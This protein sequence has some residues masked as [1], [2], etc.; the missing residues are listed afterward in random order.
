[1]PLVASVAQDVS[2]PVIA[3]LLLAARCRLA[4][5]ELAHPSTG[6]ILDATGASRSRAFELKKRL[7]ELLGGLARPSGRPPLPEPEPPPLELVFEVRDY[8]FDHPGCVTVSEV[9]REYSVEFRQFV[10]ELAER[11]PELTRDVIANAVGVP[12]GTLKDWLASPVEDPESAVQPKTTPDDSDV[13]S[14]RGLHIETVLS[15]W[16]CWRG[17]FVAFCNHLQQHCGVPFGRTLIARVLE[18]H[19]VRL[20][21]KRSGRSPDELALRGAFETFFPHAQWVGDGTMIPVEVDGELSV[22]NAE[23]HVD[24][25]S[26][27]F[28]GVHVS[29]VEDSGAVIAAFRDAIASTGRQPLALLLDNKPSN[30]TDD[31]HQ[32]VDPTMVIRATAYRPQNKAHCEGAFGLL[33]PTLDG[34]TLCGSTPEERARSFLCCL[35]ITACR[36]INHRPRQDRGGRSR[37]DLLRDEPT[38]EDIEQAQRALAERLRKQ[39]RKR[40]TLAARQD[41][42]VRA[43]LDQ[44]FRRLGLQ[45]P[46]G[47]ILTATARYPL[48]AVVDGI[49]IFE[50]RQRASTLPE[51]VDARYL[52]GIVQNIAQDRESCEIAEALWDA[53]VDAGDRLAQHLKRQQREVLADY[54]DPEQLAKAYVDRALDNASRIGL[55]FWLS[56]AA[57]TIRAR[58]PHR[59]LPVFRL[60]T[61]R[62][63]ANYTIPQRDRQTAI[64]FLAAKILP[65]C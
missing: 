37:V 26:G 31:V 12:T 5:L 38:P 36:A 45:D 32:A 27:A 54:P 4:G 56:A 43:I 49:A 3:A 50:G 58:P 42:I 57:K 25:Y 21:K 16:R 15:Q 63:Q 2:K 17:G 41:P 34:L 48:E 40:E 53:R 7:E 23:L 9:R 14:P 51:G 46:E 62:I 59:R 65:L 33:K 29:P 20:T 35:I 55:F 44:A 11:H 52:K 28:L 61:L 13:H 18:A 22:F 39:Q 1:M 10:I 60:A 64:R 30:H 47:H 8:L 19:G 24:P 6:E